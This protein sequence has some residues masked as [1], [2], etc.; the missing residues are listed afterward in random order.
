VFPCSAMG[1]PRGSS[2]S[3]F[4]VEPTVPEPSTDPAYR[5]S[6]N[7]RALRRISRVSRCPT[8]ATRRGISRQQGSHTLERVGI[9]CGNRDSVFVFRIPRRP[10]DQGTALCPELLQGEFLQPGRQ[11]SNP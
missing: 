11:V 1:G 5:C 7:A 4:A 9:E 6:T 8:T 3:G 2:G 10:L